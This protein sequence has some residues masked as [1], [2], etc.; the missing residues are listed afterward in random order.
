MTEGTSVA[1]DNGGSYQMNRGCFIALGVV[2][3]LLGFAAIGAPLVTSFA[4]TLVIGWFLIFA[5]IARGIQAIFSRGA[6]HIFLD[7]AMGIL[8]VLAGLVLL[9]NPL[10]GTLTLT[11]LVSILFIVEGIFRIVQSLQG[12]GE[13]GSGWLLVAGLLGILVGIMLLMNLPTSALW[14]IG[15][16]VGAYLIVAGFTMIFIGPAAPDVPYVSD[17]ADASAG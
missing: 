6:K 1:A 8:Y 14:A 9:R 3:I 2:V 12:W 11:L 17:V 4:M 13:K 7:L 10:A 16:L 5:G 15:L